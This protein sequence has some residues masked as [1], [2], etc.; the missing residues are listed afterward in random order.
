VDD[1]LKLT[2]DSVLK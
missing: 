2:D 1:R